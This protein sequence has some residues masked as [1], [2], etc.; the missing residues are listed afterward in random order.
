MHGNAN[1]CQERHAKTKLF[2]IFK[3]IETQ[4]ETLKCKSF[5]FLL[6]QK[7]HLKKWNV[8]GMQSINHDT[9]LCDTS[10]IIMSQLHCILAQPCLW[11]CIKDVACVN[12]FLWWASFWIIRI[13]Y[14]VGHVS[15]ITEIIYPFSM[16][17]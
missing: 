6:K 2:K 16:K 17:H 13:W 15:K 12:D 8:C 4:N 3:I 10:I 14:T 5:Q 11:G 1:E 7:W 9:F